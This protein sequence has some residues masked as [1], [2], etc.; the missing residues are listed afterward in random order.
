MKK[1]I[2][3]LLFTANLAFCQNKIKQAEEWHPSFYDYK[4]WYVVTNQNKNKIIGKVSVKKFRELLEK[5]NDKPQVWSNWTID[6]SH[7]DTCKVIIGQLMVGNKDLAKQ[8]K[9]EKL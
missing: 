2:I 6:N 4:F 3:L 9:I 1:L 7:V 8:I 5:N